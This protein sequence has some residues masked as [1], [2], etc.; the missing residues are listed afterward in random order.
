MIDSLWFE[1]KRNIPFQWSFKG[2]F[3]QLW[4][5]TEYQLKRLWFVNGL[6]YISEYEILHSYVKSEIFV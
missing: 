5:K 2:R 3:D 6:W 1:A 4:Y